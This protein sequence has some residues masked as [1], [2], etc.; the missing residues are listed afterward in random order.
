MGCVL[1]VESCELRLF[2][3]RSTRNSQLFNLACF[4]RLCFRSH[5]LQSVGK[6]GCELRVV[7]QVFSLNAQPATRNNFVSEFSPN[8]F[9]AQEKS[10]KSHVPCPVPLVPYW[11]KPVAWIEQLNNFLYIALDTSHILANFCTHT[12]LHTCTLTRL[13]AYTHI[14]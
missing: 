7:C 3:E 8:E 13:H 11:L 2:F 4:S 5:R 1:R 10:V 14:S 12:R 6:L 9:G